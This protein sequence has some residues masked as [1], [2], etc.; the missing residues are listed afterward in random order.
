MTA[1]FLRAS[2]FTSVVA[3][4]VAAL[5][6]GLGR[7]VPGDRVRRVRARS[8]RSDVVGDR[9]E[10]ESV[11]VPPVAARGWVAPHRDP[12]LV[13]LASDARS[14]RLAGMTSGA[15]RAAGARG[16]GGVRRAP[17]P[18]PD[19][20]PLAGAARPGRAARPDRRAQPVL[21]R[22]RPAG[23]VGVPPVPARTGTRTTLVDRR[24]RHLRR[25]S[26]TPPSP[27]SP[28]WRSRGPGSRSR[29]SRSSTAAP[30]RRRTSR[31]IG[32]FD[33]RYFDQDRVAVTDGRMPD[34]QR[35]RRGAREPARGRTPTATGSG[36]DSGSA[37][38]RSTR[39]RT[40]RSSTRRRTRRGRATVRIVGIGLFPDEVVQ[41]DADR[42]T[43]LLYTP[44]F[45]RAA[46]D[47]RVVRVAGPR[48]ARRRR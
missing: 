1:S 24:G 4:G 32:T 15:G 13:P 30:I 12:V 36:N 38:T 7:A 29:P 25:P 6:A 34:P 19:P 17:H 44:A 27:R 11:D 14:G 3:F 26:P 33:G 10:V 5:V 37:R 48:A 42:S 16:P 23:A 39:S 20:H 46:R 40:R 22:R 35:G 41:D 31:A 8:A 28:R 45:T 43:R 2:L 47:V 9:T 21:A 18:R